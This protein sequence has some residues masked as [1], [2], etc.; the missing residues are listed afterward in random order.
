M[1]KQQEIEKH[2]SDMA[3]FHKAL[4]SATFP[5]TS[6][7]AIAGL[8]QYIRNV[9]AQL[10]ALHAQEKQAQEAAAVL[11]EENKISDAELTSESA[12]EITQ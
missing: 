4:E 12:N 6:A 8:K 5:G 10:E 9:V 11:A 2:I 3:I 7:E 1:N